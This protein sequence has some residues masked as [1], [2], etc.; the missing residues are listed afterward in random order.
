MRFAKYLITFKN[1]L[2]NEMEFR[3][4]TV[5]RFLISMIMLVSALYLWNDVFSG[6]AEIAGY[7]KEQLVTYYILVSFIMAAIFSGLPVSE[8]IQRGNLSAYITRPINYIFY[9]Y[10]HSL[11][12]KTFRLMVGLPIL[13]AVFV[14]F[15]DYVYI[16]TDP[17]AYLVLAVSVFLALNLLFLIDILI[18]FLE[19]WFTNSFAINFIFDMSIGIFAGT[20]IPLAFLPVWV[21]SIG[22]FL[23]FQYTGAFL[24]DTFL[25]RLS[26]E[27]ILLGIGM[28]LFWTLLLAVF[29]QLI[30]ARGLKRYEAYGS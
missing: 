7:T 26:T 20:L 30:W 8:E 1:V 13:I 11:G 23:P 14:I 16:I 10:W 3:A 17:Y 9:Q 2:Q 25:G 21:V 6:R 5:V 24:V 29:A 28:Q 19:F 15:K 22:N 18:N 4:N 12:R 27:Q